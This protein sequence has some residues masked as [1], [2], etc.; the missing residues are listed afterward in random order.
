M[1]T[2]T[3]HPE[4]KLY[5]DSQEIQQTPFTKSLGITVDKNLNWKDIK[6]CKSKLACSLYAINASKPL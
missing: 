2:K 1:F 4:I 6:M 5:I 3:E